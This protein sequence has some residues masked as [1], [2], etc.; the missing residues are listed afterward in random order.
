MGKEQRHR[1]REFSIQVLYSYYLSGNP[2]DQII[3]TIASF[4]EYPEYDEEHM[5]LLVTKTITNTE[6]LDIRIREKAANWDFSRIAVIDKIILRQAIAEFLY[7][8]DVPPRVTIVEAVELAK[9]YSTEDSFS[10]INGILDKIYH[11]LVDE[12][13]IIPANFPERPREDAKSSTTDK[14]S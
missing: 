5:R 13:R 8:D 2:I 12:G 7:A 11:E 4:N 14:K 3:E 9:V 1:S 10:F 6:A